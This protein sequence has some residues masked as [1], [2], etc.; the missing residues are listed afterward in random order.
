MEIPELK[1]QHER[2]KTL[3]QHIALL[4]VLALVGRVGR[5]QQGQTKVPSKA[6]SNQSAKQLPAKAE[7]SAYD[8]AVVLDS[9]QPV[10]GKQVQDIEAVAIGD[11]GDVAVL[12]AWKNGEGI[13]NKGAW[14]A[15]TGQ[16]ISSIKTGSRPVTKLGYPSVGP[17]GSLRYRIGYDRGWSG[18]AVNGTVVWETD[19]LA[20][21][22]GIFLSDTQVLSH[23]LVNGLPPAWVGRGRVVETDGKRSTFNIPSDS[24]HTNNHGD[25]A[26]VNQFD[27]VSANTTQGGGWGVFI[28]DIFAFEAQGLADGPYINDQR[29]VAYVLRRGFSATNRGVMMNGQQLL[30][31][32]AGTS[33]KLLGFNNSK[34]PLF[35]LS[36]PLPPPGPDPHLPRLMVGKSIIATYEATLSTWNNGKRSERFVP[37]TPSLPSIGSFVTL[38]DVHALGSTPFWRLAALN[39][40]GQVVI[41]GRFSA[42]PNDWAV[43]VVS[44][45]GT[46]AKQ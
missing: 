37:G 30:E 7:T 17:N 34:T 32:G 2:K 25:V 44:P 39:N 4:L 42:H 14:V 9:S 33:Y 27:R 38:P 22:D 40:R 23:G 18:Y 13:W 36:W 8:Y 12:A 3:R 31:Y 11:N 35:L 6:A 41:A 19:Q 20:Q 24:I 21:T 5:A 28:N 45:K 29:D 10:A 46:N 15:L 26:Y 1:F 43:V 16:T